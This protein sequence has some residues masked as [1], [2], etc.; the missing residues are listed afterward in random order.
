MSEIGQTIHRAQRILQTTWKEIDALIAALDRELSTDNPFGLTIKNEEWPGDP[1]DHRY[2]DSSDAWT[3]KGWH[4]NFA[5]KR[6]RQRLGTLQICIDLN[7]D[8]FLSQTLGIPVVLVAWE[9]SGPLW[10]FNH[11]Q[12]GADAIWCPTNYSL[13]CDPRLFWWIGPEGDD[14][15]AWHKNPKRLLVDGSWFYVVPLVS[16]NDPSDLERIIVRPIGSLLTSKVSRSDKL[17]ASTFNSA[18]DVLCFSVE[19]GEFRG[20]N[21]GD[22]S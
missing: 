5:V 10:H 16:L 2:G 11:P 18:K 17:I 22:V 9:P 1:Y 15:R 3:Y 19:E 12:T 7:I 8:G 14:E 13:D 21:C 6:A 20:E 4:W